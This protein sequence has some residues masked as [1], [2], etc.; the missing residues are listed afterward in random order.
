VARSRS[1]ATRQCCPCNERRCLAG[2]AAKQERNQDRRIALNVHPCTNGIWKASATASEGFH[3]NTRGVSPMGQE[4]SRADQPRSQ[5]KNY[6]R[7]RTKIRSK[8][9]RSTSVSIPIHRMRFMQ[10][11]Q[12]TPIIEQ[13]LGSVATRKLDSSRRVVG[14]RMITPKTIDT[15]TP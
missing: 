9:G 10:R 13:L 15:T 11:L 2:Q 5:T 12:M 4:A 3:R 1:T 7:I 14:S 8:S 6:Q